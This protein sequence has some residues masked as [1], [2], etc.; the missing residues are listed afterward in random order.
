LIPWIR[1][2]RQSIHFYRAVYEAQPPWQ[3][4]HALVGL[5]DKR[6]INDFASLLRCHEH[7]NDCRQHDSR[8]GD[9]LK[10]AMGF[11]RV[12]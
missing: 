3:V 4:D 11:F 10:Q 7:P 8:I 6:E 5:R 12:V 9:P 2:S 1:I